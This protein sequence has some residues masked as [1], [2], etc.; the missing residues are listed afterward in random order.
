MRYIDMLIHDIDELN[1]VYAKRD[2]VDNVSL[3]TDLYDNGNKGVLIIYAIPYTHEDLHWRR[4]MNE[5]LLPFMIYQN[6]VD[7]QEVSIIHIRLKEKY[8][9]PD[10]GLHDMYVDI[11]DYIVDEDLSD[12]DLCIE[13]IYLAI[14]DKISSVLFKR[15]NVSHYDEDT[16]KF[17]IKIAMSKYK[18]SVKNGGK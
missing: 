16:F 10:I 2:D 9:T 18:M 11:N 1:K 5:E 3:K 8:N 13:R 14:R 4:R 15:Y 7:S 6:G 12:I 17:F